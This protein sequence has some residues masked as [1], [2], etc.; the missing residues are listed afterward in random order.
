MACFVVADLTGAKSIPQE[1]SH[2]V[3]YLPSVP[4]VPLIGEGERTDA[5]FEHFTRYQWVLPPVKYRSLDHLLSIFDARVLRA[6]YNAAMRSRGVRNPRM[7][8]AGRRRTA[9]T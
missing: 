6:G 9:G 4:M 3:P 5:M 8:K 7:P 1:L 2:I